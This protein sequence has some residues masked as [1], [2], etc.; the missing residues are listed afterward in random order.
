MASLSSWVAA[1]AKAAMSGRKGPEIAPAEGPVPSPPPRRSMESSSA[2]PHIPKRSS[3]ASPTFSYSSH[4][5]RS[6]S[7]D[8]SDNESV[9]TVATTLTASHVIGRPKRA[10]DAPPATPLAEASKRTSIANFDDFDLD[11]IAYPSSSMSALLSEK[12]TPTRHPPASRQG[13]SPTGAKNENLMRPAASE[14]ARSGWL[15][16]KGLRGWDK[17]FVIATYDQISQTGI[18]QMYLSSE[19]HQASQVLDLRNFSDVGTTHV[20]DDLKRSF[21]HK[22]FHAF[23]IRSMYSES[24]FAA[25]THADCSNWVSAVNMLFQ[26]NNSST[27]YPALSRPLSSYDNYSSQSSNGRESELF[28]TETNSGGSES[29]IDPDKFELDPTQ[30]GI[31]ALKPQREVLTDDGVRN[32]TLF[33]NGQSVPTLEDIVKVLDDRTSRVLEAIWSAYT[34]AQNSSSVAN[35]PSADIEAS[36]ADLTDS[37]EMRTS[38]I[39]KMVHDLQQRGDAFKELQAFSSD[40][41][42]RIPEGLGDVLEKLMGSLN[43]LAESNMEEVLTQV[44]TLRSS[45]AKE[46]DESS[47]DLARL[48]ATQVQISSDLGMV[49]TIL[50]ESGVSQRTRDDKIQ[51]DIQT[52]LEISKDRPQASSEGLRIEDVEKILAEK[53]PNA[54]ELESNIETKI[55]NAINGM[56]EKLEAIING[57]F[58]DHAQV[59]AAIMSVLN[60]LNGPT[61]S[62]STTNTSTTNSD[63]LLNAKIDNILEVIDFVNKSQCRLVALVAEKLKNTPQKTPEDDDSL[64]KLIYETVG[65]L[66]KN[67]TAKES[68]EIDQSLKRTNEVLERISETIISTSAVPNNLAADIKQ[69]RDICSNIQDELSSVAS[70]ESAKDIELNIRKILTLLKES[71]MEKNNSFDEKSTTARNFDNSM[72]PNELRD[73]LEQIRNKLSGI[74]R[75]FDTR[76]DLIE[77]WM[78]RNNDLLKHVV[79]GVQE[80]EKLERRSDVVAALTGKETMAKLEGLIERLETLP[81][82]KAAR[83]AEPEHFEQTPKQGVDFLKAL[84]EKYEEQFTKRMEKIEE[85]FRLAQEKSQ[86]ELRKKAILENEVAEL[87]A[88]KASLD[89]Q[90]GELE[91]KVQANRDIDDASNQLRQLEE[92]LQ[93][94]VKYLVDEVRNLSFQKQT[95]VPCTHISNKG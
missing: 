23:G 53:I 39:A 19:D 54:S 46:T 66:L 9:Q 51:K 83:Q 82:D 78:N 76:Q 2:R 3:R 71:Q 95:L 14:I 70:A 73:H 36:I 65:D 12:T 20:P 10:G 40:I 62:R 90:V 35:A 74:S 88:R 77:S 4:R 59:S 67:H 63:D 50:A 27:D 49:I 47:D 18:L 1:K 11:E 87:E 26:K 94:R 33:L 93:T 34:T 89:K 31:R 16:C 8:S 72:N 91:A 41:K 86:A 42:A 5:R 37:M 75:S 48:E 79:K 60:D 32:T 6:H 58:N 64:Q 7:N 80:L 57:K 92:D 24:V 84:G 15:W 25:S 81:S 28:S 52:L 30:F 68:K 22:E 85:D 38:R 21:A 69:V 45:F 44:S 55:K 13:L 43:R 56:H 61:H 17:H 29:S